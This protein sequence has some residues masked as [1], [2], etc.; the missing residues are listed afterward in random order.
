MPDKIR[1]PISN[2]NILFGDKNRFAIE[3]DSADNLYKM[4]VFLIWVNGI[5]LGVFEESYIKP[6][7]LAS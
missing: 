5:R 6:N 3:I 7:Y 1:T 4:G 2:D